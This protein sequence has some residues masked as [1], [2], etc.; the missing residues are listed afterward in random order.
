VDTRT[1]AKYNRDRSGEQDSEPLEPG[2]P[3]LYVLANDLP[4]HELAWL[5][6][7]DLELEAHYD[8]EA[9]TM[10]ALAAGEVPDEDLWQLAA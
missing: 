6:E 9:A 8:A 3:M 10:A 7:Q 5:L 2:A 4:A 1:G